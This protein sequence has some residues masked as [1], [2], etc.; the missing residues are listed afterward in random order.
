LEAEAAGEVQAQVE[1]HDPIA[2]Q[3]LQT[4]FG[5]VYIYICIYI[6]AMWNN[7]SPTPKTSGHQDGNQFDHK[8]NDVDICRNYIYETI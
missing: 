4:Q 1:A 2:K 3:L 5:A 8:D 7:M 6:I